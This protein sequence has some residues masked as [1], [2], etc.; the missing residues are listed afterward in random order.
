MGYRIHKVGDSIDEK[1]FKISFVKTDHFAKGE[2]VV[3]FGLFI[4]ADGFSYYHTCDTRFME[5]MVYDLDLVK[6]PTVL[7]VPIS[8]RG[9]V[10]GVEDSI[11]FT[12][13][14][15]PRIVVPGHYDSPKDKVRVSPQD[16][17][18]RFEVLKERIEAL[19]NVEVKILNFGETISLV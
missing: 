6:N 15:L 14:V 9:V 3:N 2:M 11:V 10:M 18:A 12:S 1:G 8:N 16:F 4:Q 7:S 19:E 5:T 17:E 13:Q